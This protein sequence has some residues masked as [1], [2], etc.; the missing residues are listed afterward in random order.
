MLQMNEL[1]LNCHTKKQTNKVH[2]NSVL[3]FF[4][5]MYWRSPLHFPLLKK[6]W[7]RKVLELL[8]IKQQNRNLQ[9]Q[10]NLQFKENGDCKLKGIIKNANQQQN[11]LNSTNWTIFFKE[12]TYR[13]EWFLWFWCKECQCDIKWNVCT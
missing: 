9:I 11:S 10:Y 2:L 12:S 8:F 6:V 5:Q 1:Y 13:R 4:M 7:L 3:M